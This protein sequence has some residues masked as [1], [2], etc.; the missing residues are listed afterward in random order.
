[1]KPP[2]ANCKDVA[3]Y[4]R[5]IAI[6]RDLNLSQDEIERR[7]NLTVV[8]FPRQAIISEVY[9]RYRMPPAGIEQHFENTCNNYG[10]NVLKKSLS[11]RPK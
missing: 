10:Y 2:L 6:L 7:A 9:I 5:T 1:M 11:E 4:A 3:A 8:Q